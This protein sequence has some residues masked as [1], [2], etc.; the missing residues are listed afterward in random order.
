MDKL[1]IAIAE[2]FDSPW[3]EQYGWNTLISIILSNAVIIAGIIMFI[4]MLAGGVLVIS[5]SGSDNPESKAKGR[6]AITAAVAGFLIIF[7]SYWIIRIVETITGV[8]ILNPII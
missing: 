2:P 3:G 6:K 5:G 1:A 4:L 8:D 7:T